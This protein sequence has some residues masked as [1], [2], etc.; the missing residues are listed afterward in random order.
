MIQRSKRVVLYFPRLADPEWGF[1]A[2]RDLLPLSV[3][4][5]AGI[6]DREGYEVV[7]IDG[8]LYPSEQAHRRLTQ[9]CEGALC[10]GTSSILGYQ[11]TDGLHA[12]RRV[13]AAN[14]ELPVIG[15]GWF[16]SVAPEQ[17]LRTGLF[18]AVCLGQGELTFADFVRASD[19]R[20]GID[21]IP[22]LAL[23]RDDRLVRTAPRPLAGWE[24]LPNFPWHLLEI[25]PYRDSQLAGRPS[26]ELEGPVVPPGHQ[27][28][29]FF[30][31]PYFSSFG[32]PEPC[33]FCSSP[34]V[35]GRRWKAMS[36]D[37]MLDD[38][39][40]LHDRWGFDS[41]RFFDANFGVSQK[42]MKTL[43]D[44]LLERGHHFWWYALMQSAHVSRYESETLDAM[45]DSGMYCVQLGT[46]TGDAGVMSVIGKECSP[47]VNESAIE[48]LADR[49][50]CSLATYVIGFPDE[51]EEAMMRTIDQ[52]ERVAALTPLCRAM[53]WPF[54]PIPGTV[55]YPRSVEL[56]FEPPEHLEGWS[57]ASSYHLV[58]ESPWPGQI[59]SR[60]ADRRAVY[61]H[62]ASL[63]VGLGRRRIGFWNRR[64]QRRVRERDYRHGRLEARLYTA[65]DALAR[66]LRSPRPD[67]RVA[68][69]SGYQTSILASKARARA[70]SGST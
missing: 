24:E 23:L 17:H 66:R 29:P 47:E 43:T 42:R 19:A 53:V 18:D 12:V 22:G 10:L 39:C 5:V 25:A 40:E 65:V 30:A 37:R 69:L 67:D 45:R 41:L 64:A 27:D 60:V 50:V 6:P 52:C 49:G 58:Q 35:S 55:M 7:I 46:E 28:K 8:N 68:T 63:S 2:S 9:A 15:G 70:R 26:R 54:L 14:R 33:S 16:P 32:C 36:A 3:L 51:T 38:L 48:R 11:I 1:R 59:P 56:G 4:A 13:K 20:T 34:G 61:E 44:G 21:E 57:G 31:I 62:F